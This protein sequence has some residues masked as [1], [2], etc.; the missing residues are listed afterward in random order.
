MAYLY[1]KR[2][3]KWKAVKTGSRQLWGKGFRNIKDEMLWQ[4]SR[5]TNRYTKR[6]IAGVEFAE[7]SQPGV[8]IDWGWA[9]IL[10]N[11]AQLLRSLGYKD[12][13]DYP[14]SDH[15]TRYVEIN[16]GILNIAHALFKDFKIPHLTDRMIDG[17]D[18]D[19]PTA[20]PLIQQLTNFHS[21]SLSHPFLNLPSPVDFQDF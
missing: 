14:T 20:L 12:Y 11:I 1:V 21:A 13:D 10:F 4:V 7:F 2:S 3:V 17:D 15:Y 18:D 9:P 16:Y 8:N 19:D 5:Y 6:M